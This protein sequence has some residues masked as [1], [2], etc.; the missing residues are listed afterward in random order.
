M[1][2]FYSKLM[3]NKCLRFPDKRRCYTPNAVEEIVNR[4]DDACLRDVK[5]F[6][7]ERGM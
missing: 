7:L 1:G 3:M 5:L 6:S 4:G 2:V